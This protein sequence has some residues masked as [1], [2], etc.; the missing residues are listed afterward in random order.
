MLK[1]I[2]YRLSYLPW[3]KLAWGAWFSVIGL[4]LLTDWGVFLWIAKWMV[5][6]VVGAIITGL[7]L[8][9]LAA[10]W[11][12]ITKVIRW[13]TTTKE[14]REQEKAARKTRRVDA[15]FDHWEPPMGRD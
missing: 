7:T 14:Q 3:G 15:P 5:F 12:S 10:V 4:A 11:E 8:G 13:L 2:L 1:T 9:F 6:L